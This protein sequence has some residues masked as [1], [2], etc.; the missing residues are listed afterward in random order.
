MHC[1]CC[2]SFFTCYPSLFMRS[3]LL[4]RIVTKS[5]FYCALFVMCVSS[6]CHSK[7]C[8]T[9]Y[10]ILDLSKCTLSLAKRQRLNQKVNQASW[11]D[12]CHGLPDLL[13]ARLE[14]VQY[15]S[16]RL[17]TDIY[18]YMSILQQCLRIHWLPIK[19]RYESNTKYV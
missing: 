4:W 10:Y 5:T 11:L 8:V 12:F 3:P 16:A 17:K 2:N 6:C 1:T 19:Y 7:L 9:S 15:A 14:R 13:L 18:L